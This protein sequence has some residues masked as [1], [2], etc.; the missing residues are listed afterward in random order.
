MMTVS[1][2]CVSPVRHP[3]AA[4]LRAT[5]PAAPQTVC[6]AIATSIGPARRAPIASPPRHT[7]SAHPARSAATSQDRSPPAREYTADVNAPARLPNSQREWTL[8]A[9]AVPLAWLAGF[10]LV[11]LLLGTR[12]PP[13]A[14][15]GLLAVPVPVV[16]KFTR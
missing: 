1:L 2:T 6:E 15:L 13:W 16:L 12:W 8:T 14:S 3:G 7:F 10:L 4:L 9:Q 5:A 11:P